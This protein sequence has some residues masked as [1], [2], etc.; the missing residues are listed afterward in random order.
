MYNASKPNEFAPRR[1]F[2]YTDNTNE[3]TVYNLEMISEL[4]GNSS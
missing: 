2:N 4:S 3:R 1:F